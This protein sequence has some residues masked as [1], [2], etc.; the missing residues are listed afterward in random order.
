M[1]V[2]T[3][4]TLDAALSRQ[5]APVVMV[6]VVVVALLMVGLLPLQGIL[7]GR[8]R[9][10]AGSC[11]SATAS[12]FTGVDAMPAAAGQRR[13]DDSSIRRAAGSH[14]VQRGGAAGTVV[15][16]PRARMTARG[17]RT[18]VQRGHWRDGGR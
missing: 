13:M 14:R 3:G 4:R 9:R 15:Q 7:V 6:M 17:A 18:I 5:G 2:R 16:M 11:R 10:R 1:P 8:Q 12:T